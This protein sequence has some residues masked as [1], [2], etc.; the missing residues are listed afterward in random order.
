MIN[1]I[2]NDFIEL[3]NIY[4]FVEKKH[5]NFVNI[6]FNVKLE[7]IYEIQYRKIKMHDFKNKYVNDVYFESNNRWIKIFIFRENFESENDDDDDD[8]KN[9][10]ETTFDDDYNVSQKY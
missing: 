10:L 2:L 6:D 3:F 4:D 1:E 8:K 9:A 7:Q 5:R